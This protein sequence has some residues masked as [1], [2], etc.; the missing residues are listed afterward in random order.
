M[1]YHSPSTKKHFAKANAKYA[2]AKN[3]FAKANFQLLKKAVWK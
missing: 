2:K 1:K 3:I